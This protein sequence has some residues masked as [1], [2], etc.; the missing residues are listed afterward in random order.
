MDFTNKVCVITGGA[1]G[2]GRCLVEAFRQAG[3]YVAFIDTDAAA[4]Q[5]LAARHPEHSLFMAGDITAEAVLTSFSQAVIARFHHI[6]Y[7]INNACSSKK[8]LLSGCSY[9]DFNYVLTLGITAPYLLTQLFL[10]YFRPGGSIINIAST[11]AFM[12][13]PDTESYTAAKGGISA[14]THALSISLH[15]RLRVNTISPGWI[16]TGTDNAPAPSSADARQ[17]PAGRIGQPGDI[18]QA[19]LFLCSDA[20][21]FITGENLVID[22]GMSK[23]MIYHGD[24]GWSWRP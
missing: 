8:G 18:A 6:D 24:H 11:R 10:P 9:A 14:L 21:S 23:Q 3:A 7:L 22:G 5:K 1:N 12:S 19:A 13:Q 15:G 17:H 16:H 4:G 20:A 2:I